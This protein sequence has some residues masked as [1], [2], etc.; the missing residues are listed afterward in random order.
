MRPR[1][2]RAPV[3]PRVV[4]GRRFGDLSMLGMGTAGLAGM[5][6]SLRQ[7]FRT[8]QIVSRRRQRRRNSKGEREMSRM[9]YVTQRIA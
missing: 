6:A 7:R 8:H 9:A 2:G 4:T 1:L 5:F 3:E